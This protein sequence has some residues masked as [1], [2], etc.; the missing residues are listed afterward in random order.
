MDA[1]DVVVDATTL[2]LRS[3]RDPDVVRAAKQGICIELL[4]LTDSAAYHLLAPAP[5]LRLRAELIRDIGVDFAAFLLAFVLDNE[6]P[7]EVGAVLA[8]PSP[9]FFSLAV[10]RPGGPGS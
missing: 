5:R 8:R 1:L 7:A 9:I 3:V 10:W 4:T 6:A 2:I